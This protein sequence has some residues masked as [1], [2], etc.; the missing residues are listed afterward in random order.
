MNRPGCTEAVNTRGERGQLA[1]AGLSPRAAGTDLAMRTFL[2]LH[3][4]GRARRG[5]GLATHHH[6]RRKLLL[7][8]TLGIPSSR[9]G[10]VRAAP[11]CGT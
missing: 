7:R 2:A 3:R 11:F 8:F 1:L 5:L 10:T 6:E 9:P 4:A